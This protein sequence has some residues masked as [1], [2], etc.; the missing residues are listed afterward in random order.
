MA[1]SDKEYSVLA[2]AEYNDARGGANQI[3][4]L[5]LGFSKIDGISDVDN[6]VSGLSIDAYQRGSDIVIDVKGT[7]FLLS[8][9]G[10]TGSD[11]AADIGLGGALGLGSSQIFKAAL[12]YEQVKAA[13]P[14]A[15]ITFTGHSLGAG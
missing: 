6:P 7:D 1:I 14:G 12:F 9:L 8:Q 5:P 3:N 2:A 4:Y 15:N 11:L 13:N 10:R